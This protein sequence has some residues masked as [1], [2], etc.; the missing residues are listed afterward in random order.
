MS[1]F[2]IVKDNYYK[3]PPWVL[4][5]GGA[6]YY[7]LPRR[8]RYGKDFCDTTRLLKQT[9]YM[10]KEELDAAVNERFLRTVR[11]A[12]ENV[13]FYRRRFDEHGVRMDQIRDV[14]DI[15]RL[16][17]TDKSD[18]RAFAQEMLSRKADPSRLMILQTSG[19]TGE[20]ASQYQP[21]RM[22]MVEWAYVQHIWSR[23]GLRPES[24][25]LVLRGKRI[26]PGAPDPDVYY[27][28]LRREL[29]VN[30][31]N[32]TPGNLEKYCLAIEQYRPEYIHGYPSSILT[33]AQY[34]R[35]RP[36]GLK[37]RFRGI[38]PVSEGLL[39]HQRTI[40]E[41]TFRCPVLSFYGHTER[42]LIAGECADS[43]EYHIEPLYGYA[44]V[45]APDGSPARTGELVVTGFLND[46]MPLIRY[47]TGDMVTLSEADSCPCGRAHRRIAQI[48]GRSNADVLIDCDGKAIPSHFGC[49]GNEFDAIARYKFIQH[50]PGEV[51]MK[52]IPDQGFTD[53]TL[54]T[55]KNSLEQHVNG[56]IRFHPELTDELPL[57]PNGKYRMVEQ[58]I[59]IE[60]QVSQ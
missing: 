46:A 32:M 1:L 30:I 7:C 13:P 23:I 49:H 54:E 8:L 24:S 58:H 48:I 3:I 34:I 37:H 36:G 9:E 52:I 47:R 59:P 10:S 43:G 17:V 4:R 29:S 25:R 51:T 31:F 21:K 19:S 5:F 38:L 6:L 56:R 53:S 39:S 33:L 15:T 14:S 22:L 2:N 16:P 20:P 35:T 57:M 42:Q 50:T 41:E 12:Y 18:I 27:D 44:E 26:H 55:L 11:D 40:L 60:G 45:L 28:H